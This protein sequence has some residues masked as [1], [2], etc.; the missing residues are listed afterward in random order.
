LKILL[1]KFSIADKGQILDSSRPHGHDENTFL[2][3]L[4]RILIK[5]DP[6][7]SKYKFERQSN[8]KTSLI[9]TLGV[10]ENQAVYKKILSMLSLVSTMYQGVPLTTQEGSQEEEKKE[11]SKEASPVSQLALDQVL[12]SSDEL[13]TYDY[14]DVD[15]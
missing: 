3:K 2:D 10:L 15:A 9:N 14:A 1:P 8:F 6:H 13:E 7:Y 11:E 5:G 12:F 4:N